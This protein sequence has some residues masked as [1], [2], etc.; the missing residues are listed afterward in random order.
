MARLSTTS[1]ALLG[2]LSMAPMSGYDLYQAVQRSVRHMWP[3]SKS[4]VYAEVARLE[5]LGL[6]TATEVRQQ[7]LPDKRVLQL[8]AAG[9]EALDEWLAGGELPP[10]QFRLP[11]LL[12][13][14]FGHRLG[15][16]PVTK[17][18]QEIQ[19]GSEGRR[20]EYQTLLTEM[21]ES[22]GTEYAQ[23]V[24]LCGLRM[25]E[26]VAAW[27]LEAQERVPAHQVII[28]PRRPEP[29]TAPRMFRA[30]PVAMGAGDQAREEVGEE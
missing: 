14:L 3:I 9:E 17:L 24:V 7:H 2:L 10:P 23:L 25:A 27:A 22:P 21:E 18:L 19:A 30:A 4:Q 20:L 11:F 12:H 8:T 13:T 15:P 16:E 1:Y 29:R 5:P 6:I 28:D 26:A